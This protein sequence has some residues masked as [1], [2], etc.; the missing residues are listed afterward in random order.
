MEQVQV[1][2]PDGNVKL[3]I[4]PNAERLSFTVTLADTVVIDP[5]TIVMNLDGYDLSSGVVL[6]NV[7]CYEIDETYPWHGAHNTAV[8]QCNGAKI[9]LQHDLSFIDYVLEVRAF[10][11]GAAFRHVIAGDEGASRVPDEYTTFVI[12]AGSMVWYHDLG[13]HYEAAY[14]NNDISDVRRDNGPGRP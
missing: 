9:S 5:S 14:E 13:G 7:D 11:D 4:L 10:N 1:A 12:P 3:T 2:S 6:G 8:N